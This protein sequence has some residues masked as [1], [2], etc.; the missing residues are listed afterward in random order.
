[1]D[2]DSSIRLSQFLQYLRT[3]EQAQK[4][5]REAGLAEGRA[6]GQKQKAIDASKKLIKAGIDLETI[7]KYEGL[8]IEEVERLSLCSHST[9]NTNNLACYIS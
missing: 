1:M 7:A 9:V 2:Y 5:G 6:E 3:K 4:E 8:S